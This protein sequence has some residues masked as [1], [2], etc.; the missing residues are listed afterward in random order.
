[1]KHNTPITVR[2]IAATGAALGA[3]SLI[4]LATA[5]TAN[6]VPAPT[7][8]AVQAGHGCGTV[9][10]EQ[11]APSAEAFAELVTFAVCL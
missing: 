8:T 6:A 4:G 7:G 5:P 11:A 2:R 1:M 10:G 9:I 3:A